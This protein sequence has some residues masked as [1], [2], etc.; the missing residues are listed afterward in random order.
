MQ[1]KIKHGPERVK[2]I[3]I[4]CGPERVMQFKITYGLGNWKLN[5]DQKKLGKY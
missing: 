1:F 4:K 3:E 2:Q 5:M